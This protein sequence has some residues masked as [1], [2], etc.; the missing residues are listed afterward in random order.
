MLE[1]LAMVFSLVCG[2]GSTLACRQQRSKLL[3][4]VDSSVR[5]SLLTGR[6]LALP[7]F[8]CQVITLSDVGETFQGVS[9]C[10]EVPYQNAVTRAFRNQGLMS[11]V[12]LSYL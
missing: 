2:V 12:T 7:T 1:F 10:C 5:L 3:S 6:T 8:Q 9:I 4:E 11:V